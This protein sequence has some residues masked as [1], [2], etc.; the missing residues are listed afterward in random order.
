MSRT[1]LDAFSM[2]SSNFFCCS[3]KSM[4]I[5]LVSC[6][7]NNALSTQDTEKGHSSERDPYPFCVPQ[8]GEPPLHADGK[9]RHGINKMLCHPPNIHPFSGA[10]Q[11]RNS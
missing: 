9:L 3:D 10:K 8:L 1:E 11:G 4:H 5:F 2:V 6:K 7:I